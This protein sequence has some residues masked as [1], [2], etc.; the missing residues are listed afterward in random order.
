MEKKILITG[1]S[2]LVGTRLTELLVDQGYEVCHLGRSKKSGKIKSFV[3]NIETGAFDNSALAGVT[4]IIHLA[5]AGVADKRW[6][7]KRK[8]EILQSRIK[9]TALLFDV[10]KNTAHGVESIVSASAIGYYSFSE[11]DEVFTEDAESGNGF[12]ADV[13]KHW[14]HEVD[15]FNLLNLRT[16]K[17]RIGIVLSDEGG[18]LVQMAMPIK[19]GVG[20]PLATGKQFLSW[21]H[22]DDLC[23]MFIKAIEDTRMRGAFNAT[24]EWASNK[25]LTAAIAKVVHKPIWLPNVP[26]F[27][28]RLI[29]GEMADMI[30]NGSKVTSQ[31]IQQLGF[32][33]KY[34]SLQSALINLLHK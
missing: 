28:L 12:L 17:L 3:W 13:T 23:L 2:G 16:V 22:I 9:S 24:T 32:V 21:I 11:S 30:I 33:P 34:P 31:K 29:V 7:K 26:A 27:M 6:T 19:L 25:E 18:A 5:G 20:S 4:S 8:E 15:K 1:A 14:E 10:L